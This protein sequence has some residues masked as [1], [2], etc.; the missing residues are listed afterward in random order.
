[1]AYDR[2][3]KYYV[4]HFFTREGVAKY[5]DNRV[6][7]LDIHSF[8]QALVVLSDARAGQAELSACVLNWMLRHL[9]NPKGYFYFRR[10][11]FHVNRI[12]YMRWSQAWAFHALTCYLLNQ[13]GTPA[14]LDLAGRASHAYLD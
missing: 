14:W 3:L 9:W 11:R 7:P 12:C 4:E 8:C 5:Y 6:F 13:T 1:M 2:G 10:G